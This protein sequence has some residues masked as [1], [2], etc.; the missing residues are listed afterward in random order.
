MC[1]LYHCFCDLRIKWWNT[2]IV[3]KTQCQN[4]FLTTSIY[5]KNR[6]KNNK[7]LQNIRIE[8]NVLTV[9]AKIDR[10]MSKKFIQKFSRISEKHVE[11]LIEIELIEISNRDSTAVIDVL[12]ELCIIITILQKIWFFAQKRW[13][14][15]VRSTSMKRN[16]FQIT[17]I[18]VNSVIQN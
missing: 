7:I 1:V 4:A 8:N 16:E 13:F 11:K 17:S 9:F 2:N 12:I 5:R 3:K 15:A 14:Y 18:L 10:F 6:S